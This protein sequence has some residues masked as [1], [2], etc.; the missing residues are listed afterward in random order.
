MTQL[1]SDRDEIEIQASSISESCV[2][3][4]L[5]HCLLLVSAWNPPGHIPA[6]ARDFRDVGSIHGPGRSLGGEHGNPLQY[7]CLEN[8][9]IKGTW[10]ATFHWF[11]KNW[12]RLT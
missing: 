10:G 4:P 6:N 7:S 8:P 12:I 1:V 9:M 3:S 5:P 2:L 11:A